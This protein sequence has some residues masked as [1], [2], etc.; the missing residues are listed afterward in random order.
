[1]VKIL[2]HH[3]TSWELP[4]EL[5]VSTVGDGYTVPVFVGDV[6]RS[7]TARLMLSALAGASGI[8]AVSAV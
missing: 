4:H 2:I 6:A 5:S 7:S 8:G 1:M 3:L